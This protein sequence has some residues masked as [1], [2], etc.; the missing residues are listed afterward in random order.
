LFLCV[1]VDV[2]RRIKNHV[3]QQYKLNCYFENTSKIGKNVLP[4]AGKDGAIHGVPHIYFPIH[5]LQREY[6]KSAFVPASEAGGW[7]VE[8]T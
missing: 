4:C 2:S 8:T 5:L 1:C 7:I 3:T 6:D